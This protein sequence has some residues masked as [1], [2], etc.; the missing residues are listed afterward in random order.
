MVMTLRK[1]LPANL[2]VKRKEKLLSRRTSIYFE[3]RDTHSVMT[4]LS[5]PYRTSSIIK[6]PFLNDL[7]LKTR[8]QK[9]I[10]ADSWLFNSIVKQ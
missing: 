9:K 10:K 4:F 7:L 2:M 8:L 3:V 1:K 5:N 6:P